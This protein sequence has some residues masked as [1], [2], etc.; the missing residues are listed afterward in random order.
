MIFGNYN[1]IT[2]HGVA[3][4]DVNGTITVTCTQ[5]TPLTIALDPGHHAAHAIGTTR[6]MKHLSS[7]DY[8][9]YEL[10]QDLLRTTVWGSSGVTLFVPPVAPNKN[11][12]AFLIYGRVPQEQSRVA[13]EY[14]DTI[15]A[16]VNF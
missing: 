3:P 9:N 4:L 16:I 14:L 10:Y 8:L 6:A 15:V 5:G 13:G 11:P 2:T 12:R 7:T 1:A